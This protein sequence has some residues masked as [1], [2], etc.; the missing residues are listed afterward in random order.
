MGLSPKPR[1]FPDYGVRI[2][3]LLRDGKMGAIGSY[4]DACHKEDIDFTT[5]EMMEFGRWVEVLVFWLIGSLTEHLACCFPSSGFTLLC[6]GLYC[7]EQPRN[8]LHTPST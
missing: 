5:D 8:R 2:Y 1:V 7:G 4:G 6:S 3:V